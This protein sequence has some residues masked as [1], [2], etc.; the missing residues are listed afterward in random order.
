MPHW[1]ALD[2]DSFR[3]VCTS[4]MQGMQ[5]DVL[6]DIVE[7]VCKI[8]DTTDATHEHMLDG[9]K[10]FFIYGFALS[11]KYDNSTPNIFYIISWKLYYKN[12]LVQKSDNVFENDAWR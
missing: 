3:N 7:F 12:C 4:V 2:I 1:N 8:I 10:I 6:S 11:M 9:Q 5:F